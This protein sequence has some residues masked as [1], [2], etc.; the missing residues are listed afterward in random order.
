MRADVRAAC[1][2]LV[3]QLK[4]PEVGLSADIDP[5]ALN[6]PCVWVQPRQIRDRRLGGGATLVAWC[7][8]ISGSTD[9]AAAMGALD[10]ALAPL[11]E[12]VDVAESDDVIDLA[13][14][15]ILPTNPGTP[16]PAYR[17]AVDLDL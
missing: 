12:V 5:G 16:L 4:A 3:D 6:P 15:V 9:T 10:D 17:V 13:A 14:A 2:A 7:Y 1:L 11:L 8:V